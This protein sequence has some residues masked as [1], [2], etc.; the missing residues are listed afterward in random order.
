MGVRTERRLTSPGNLPVGLREFC[1]K[2]SRVASLGM[3]SSAIM[4]DFRNSLTVVSGN[5]QIILLK[6]GRLPQPEI[7]QRLGKVMKQIER[8]TGSFDRVGSFSRRAAGEVTEVNPYAALDNA[9][10]GL[11]R[12]IDARQAVLTRSGDDT[13][14]K[15]RCD[16]SLF[17]F[18]LLELLSSC[19]EVMRP[20]GDLNVKTTE[21]DG[22]WELELRLP[23]DAGARSVHGKLN[24]RAESFSTVAMLLAVEEMGGELYLS[25]GDKA[26][27]WSLKMPLGKDGE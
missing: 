11:N 12:E 13:Q 9:I 16:A 4:H 22:W 26:D 10:F 3:V 21:K 20:G 15:I 27:G 5:V 8:I 14:G 6:Q 25:S 7:V 18:V 2:F 1:L 19:L 17:E 24:K 23:S